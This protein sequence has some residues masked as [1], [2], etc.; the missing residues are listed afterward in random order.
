MTHEKRPVR[1]STSGWESPYQCA[2]V[3]SVVRA[4]PRQ[5]GEAIEVYLRRIA[6]ASGL[7]DRDSREPGED[8]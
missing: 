2:A 7:I 6:I 4:N 5:K 8:G 3:I 1:E